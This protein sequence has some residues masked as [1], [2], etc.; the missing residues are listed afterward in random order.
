MKKRWITYQETPPVCPM[1]YW[2]HREVDAKLP[3]DATEFD[4][5]R[6]G[7]VATRGY[8]V[9]HV[10]CDRLELEF[11]SFAEMETCIETLSRKVLPRP[12]DLSRERG[13][14]KGPN[15]HWLARL[16]AGATSWKSRQKA[17]AWLRESLDAFRRELV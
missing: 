6:Q 8:P 5:P 13:T 12:I 9:F 2:V 15:S 7:R 4:P 14:G 10:T 1:T 11:A 3:C 16:P 17:L